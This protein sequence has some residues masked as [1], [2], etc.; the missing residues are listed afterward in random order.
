VTH[1]DGAGRTALAKSGRATLPFDRRVD[2]SG[3]VRLEITRG[4]DV[5][6]RAIV[7]L[8][9]TGRSQGLRAGELRRV[10]ADVSVVSL[11]QPVVAVAAMAA[12]AR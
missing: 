6:A 7:G 10:L 2:E 8:A 4:D 12:F 9:E 3:I 11:M 5:A 1:R